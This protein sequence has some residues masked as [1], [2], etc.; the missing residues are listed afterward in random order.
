MGKVLWARAYTVVS[1]EKTGKAE[2]GLASVNNFS[3][4]CNVGAVV[5]CLVP[6]PGMIRAGG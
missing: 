1:T 4:L 6:G 5:S 3:E 2:L